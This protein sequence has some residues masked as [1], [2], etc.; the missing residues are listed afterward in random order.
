MVYQMHEVGTLLA[1]L[2][3]NLSKRE[4]FLT[5]LK[6]FANKYRYEEEHPNPSF[7]LYTLFFGEDY[8]PTHSFI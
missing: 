8:V 2:L 5:L 7:K 3:P 6:K 1:F 4:T